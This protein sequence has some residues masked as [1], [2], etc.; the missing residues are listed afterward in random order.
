MEWL[1]I[2]VLI[3]GDLAPNEAEC[4]INGTLRHKTAYR[5]RTRLYLQVKYINMAAHSMLYYYTMKTQWLLYY[6]FTKALIDM[7]LNETQMF[8]ESLPWQL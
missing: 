7:C 5:I 8:Y 4:L 2:H 6:T 1:L 3:S